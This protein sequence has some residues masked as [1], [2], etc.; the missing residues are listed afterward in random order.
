MSDG[1][2]IATLDDLVLVLWA[3]KP[4]LEQVLE[5]RKVIELIE[6]RYN[7]GSSIHVLVNRPELPDKHVRAEM[8]RVTQ[9]YADHSI[10]SALVLQG[11]G[12]WASAMRG[13]ATSLHFFGTK[14]DRFK[15]RVCATVERAASWLAPLHNERS[16]RPVRVE[17]VT[18]ALHELSARVARPK[19]RV[20]RSFI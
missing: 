3:D 12:F 19:V 17:D 1:C 9:D 10:A 6:Y 18:A 5:L 15:F 11:D 2:V 13:L 20:S 8:A 14:R 4:R 16:R 7:G